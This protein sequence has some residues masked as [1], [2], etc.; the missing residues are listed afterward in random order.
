MTESASK[1]S[2]TLNWERLGLIYKPLGDRK[3]HDNSALQPSVLRLDENTLRVYFGARDATGISRVSFI[4]VLEDDPTKIIREAQSPC[5]DIGA[6]GRFDDNGVVPCFATKVGDKVR[7][8]YAGYNLQKRVRF[9]VFSGLAESSDG[10][11]S[12]QRYSELPITE[13]REGES[14]FRVIHSMITDNGQY[15]VWYGGGDSFMEG[16]Q[17]TLPIYNV[18]TQT[19]IDGLDFSS[20]GSLAIDMAEGEHRLGRPQVVA[21]PLESKYAMFYGYGSEQRPYQLGMALSDDGISWNRQDERLGLP[22]SDGGFDSQMMAYPCPVYTRD[23]L[24]LF[25]N[26]NDY[27]RA[28]IGVAALRN[29]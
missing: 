16:I 24:L 19:S 9:T 14:L 5:L 2:K 10:G 3:W 6:P 7:L 11:E 12:F 23:G 29:S 26:G 28:G 17:K 25:Y 21:S 4:D 13:R 27:G 1:K 15:R 18:R 8:Y 22:L 20:P